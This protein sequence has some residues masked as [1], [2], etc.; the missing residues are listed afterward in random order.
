M[1][2]LERYIFRQAFA[3]FFLTM[4]SLIGVLY[5]TQALRELDLVTSKGQ[6]WSIFVTMTALWMPML[7]MIISPVA[8]LIAAIYVL[9]KLNGDS[10]LVVMTASGASHWR[11]VKPFLLLA[12]I[13]SAVI[14]YIALDLSPRSLKMMR[15]YITQIRADLVGNV[16]RAGRFSELE[17]GLVFHI[18]AR[19]PDGRMIGI[20]VDDDRDAETAVTYFAESG[21]LL[22]TGT[23][24]FLAM[25]DG[26]IHRKTRE[27]GAVNIIRYE[28]YAFDLS[29][30]GGDQ[31]ITFYK[32]RERMTSEL[33]NPDPDD[34]Y[35]KNAPGRVRV[36][37]HDRL[38]NPLYPLAFI[39]VILAALGRP[40]TTRQARGGA[41]LAA[42]AIAGG[43]RLAGFFFSNLAVQAPWAIVLMY[44]IPLAAI[45]ISIA[46]IATGYEIRLPRAV[47]GAIGDFGD[48][49]RPVYERFARAVGPLPE[50]G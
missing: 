21:Q 42:G 26:S 34:L 1:K 13:V 48:R 49:L 22:E 43:I 9:N 10:E 3:A 33:I 38:S 44:A 37:L 7:V 14:A 28:R 47:S 24:T 46:V 5:V 31:E 40:R 36:E 50:R 39:F 4:V 11:V 32:P 27:T 12:L 23:G 15:Y 35:Y 19:A 18:R 25:F 45:V 8:L 41:I 6:T 29:Q 17:S 2:L 16:L 20:M 30:F